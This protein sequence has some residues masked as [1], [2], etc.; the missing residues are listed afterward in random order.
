MFA[1][2]K[3]EDGTNLVHAAPSVQIEV[4]TVV[5]GPRGKST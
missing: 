1:V 4:N 3:L 5:S 2:K